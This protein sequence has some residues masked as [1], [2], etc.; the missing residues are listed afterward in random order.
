MTQKGRASSFGHQALS[1]RGWHVAVMAYALGLMIWQTPVAA[2]AGLVALAGCWL[3]FVDRPRTLLALLLAASIGMLTTSAL[4]SEPAAPDI[5]GSEPAWLHSSPRQRIDGLVHDV[6]GRTGKRLR[7]VLR[8]VHRVLP[9]GPGPSLGPGLVLT[10]RKPSQRPLVGQRL[11]VSVYPKPVRGFRTPGSMDYSGYWRKKG[12]QWRAYTSSDRGRP[13]LSGTAT[14]SARMREHVRSAVVQAVPRGQGGA[15]LL[16]MLTGDR[17]RISVATEEA[18]RGAGLAH[19]L[20]LSGLHV[21]FVAGLGFLLAWGVGALH[22]A[23]F[24]RV[25]RHRLAVMLAAP[26]VASYVWLGGSAPSLLRAGFMFASFGFCL[27]FLR[28]GRALLDGLFGAVGIILVVAPQ[29]VNDLGLR[30][31]AVA[32]LCIV[33]GMPV[34]RSLLLRLLPSTSLMQRTARAVCMVLGVSLV[35]TL[36]LLP[37]TAST[38]GVLHPNIL[39]NLLWLPALGLV[40]MPLGLLSLISAATGLQALAGWAAAPAAWLMELLVS[41]LSWGAKQGLLPSLVLLR[42]FWPELLGFALVV[43]ACAFAWRSG[44]AL[45]RR[46]LSVALCGVL[47]MLATHAAT[48]VVDARAPL[49]LRLLDV[50]QGQCAV[51]TLP[52]GSRWLVDAGGPW[53]SGFHV[54]EAVI[55]PYLT[56]GRPPRVEGLVLSHPDVDHGGG[57]AYLLRHFSPDRFI[58]NGREPGGQWGARLLAELGRGNVEVQQVG[59]ADTVFL[60][61]A[62]GQTVGLQVLHGLEPGADQSTNDGSLVLRLVHGRKG[63]ALLPGDVEQDGIERLLQSSFPLRSQVLVLPHHG[64]RGSMSLDLYE[65]VRPEQAW[66]SAGY[67]NHYGH[68]SRGVVDSL[69]SLN[70]PL[71]STS[72][73]GTLCKLFTFD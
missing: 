16:A 41:M 12:V 1:L 31:S 28:R 47:L 38:F 13:V 39:S 33:L 70:I 29:T 42:P 58:W 4:L 26:L 67:L 46:A 68:P 57:M 3:L 64:S 71:E 60:G 40:V 10:W 37:I 18:L 11:S 62:G 55:G 52:G 8:D 22:P 54:V 45:S 24:L 7:V 44:A 48:A 5:V 61:T 51:I 53:G 15:I 25:P 63:L 49:S 34:F 73:F 32:V 56:S 35:A 17:S 72:S 30:M 50:G 6:T 59:P 27:L 69:H 43:A 66:A 19:T 2:L 65:Q 14:A 21:G 9:G 36:G 23:I 20:A